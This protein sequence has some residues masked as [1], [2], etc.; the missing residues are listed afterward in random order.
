M[1]IETKVGLSFAGF[2]LSSIM[3]GAFGYIFVKYFNQDVNGEA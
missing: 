2:V 3:T 1:K